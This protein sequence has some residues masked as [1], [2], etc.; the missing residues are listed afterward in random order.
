MKLVDGRLD[1]LERIFGTL[2]DTE[3]DPRCGEGVLVVVNRS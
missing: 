1:D 3:V 2:Q